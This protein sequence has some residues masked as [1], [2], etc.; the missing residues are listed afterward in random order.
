MPSY[1]CHTCGLITSGR[2]CPA[3]QPDRRSPSSRVTGTSRWRKLKAKVL[4]RDRFLCH[5]CGGKATTA[6]HVRAVGRGGAKYDEANV[7]ASC[8]PCN[9]TKGARETV[10]RT[11]RHR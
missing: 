10:D 5:Y 6:D 1:A 11:P 9:L 2:Y 4:R 8:V 3:H 7:V